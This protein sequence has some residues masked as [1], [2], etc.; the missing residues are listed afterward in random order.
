MERLLSVRGLQVWFP[1]RTGFVAGLMKGERK[2][3]RAVDGIDFDVAPSEI[4][5]LVGESGC[6]KTTTGKAILRLNEPT[7]GS[8][9]F[10]LSEQDWNRVTVVQ[11]RLEQLKPI[12]EKTGDQERAEAEREF[13]QLAALRRQ[14]EQIRG[15]EGAM[16]S[17]P[18]LD[19]TERSIGFLEGRAKNLREGDD[20]TVV[21]IVSKG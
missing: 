21:R 16:R 8:L 4:F 6:G 5:C 20:S 19:R 12:L 15:P 13:Q 9:L 18:R 11:Q 10:A 7:G 17:D 14:I 2:F 3:V 1:V